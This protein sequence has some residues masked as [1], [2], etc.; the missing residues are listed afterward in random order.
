MPLVRSD[1]DYLRF[2]AEIKRSPH[3]PL[4]VDTETTGLR[5]Y[6]GD[7]I[8]GISI[9]RA[10]RE[11]WYL[12]VNHVD[13]RNFSA[14][15]VLI[16]LNKHPGLLVWH[17]AKFDW[18]MLTKENPRVDLSTHP[19]YDTQVGA[20]YYDEN[21]PTG[22]K[23]NAARLWGEEAKEEQR[24]LK[25]L[26]RGGKTWADLM[27]EEIADY[28]AKDAELTIRLMDSQVGPSGPKP[29]NEI[30]RELRFQGVL[31]RMIARGIRVNPDKIVEQATKARRR[32]IELEGEFEGV[33]LDS[34]PQLRQLVYEDWGVPVKHRTPKGQP[35]TNRQALE[36]LEGHPK[37]RELLEYR[38]LRKAW[39]AYYRPLY[40]TIGDDGRIHPHF[41]STRTV[42]GRL[43]CSDPNLMTI[44]RADTLEGVRDIFLPEDGYE[45]WEY[46]LKSA[47]LFIQASLCKDENLVR[48]LMNGDDL[49]NVTAEMV[50]GPD[51]T[52][53]QRRLAKNL[54]Y[55]FSYG[56]GPRKFAT[57]LVANTPES[58]TEC[59][60]W[61][62]PF[63]LPDRPPRCESCHVCQSAVLLDQYRRAYPRL[64]R[65]MRGLEDAA[66]RDGYLPLHVPGRYR[67]FRSAGRQVP[68][69]TALNAIVQ[70]GVAELVKDVMLGV[71][72]EL[73]ALG[74]RLCLQVHDSLV[75][76]VPPGSGPE[77]GQAIQRV[78]NDVNTFL[79][80]MTWDAQPWS[81]HD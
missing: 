80:P 34:A 59:T 9:A 20:W 71:E 48:A 75:I 47:E 31:Y 64:V 37:V 42:T 25:A 62:W 3:E 6:Q 2:L 23:E 55:G 73:D 33:N 4:A 57:Y 53:L 17:H 38:R 45:L 46:D 70:G 5:P 60:H 10:G 15:D 32:M 51:F 50:F 7:H 22:L 69:Y 14:H 43:S 27:A 24:A 72:P 65:L 41:S 29:D 18:A 63:G 58:V 12:P 26:L 54:N 49:H 68:Y 67:R 74:A 36:E 19:F 56:I 11:G 16:L 79:L 39:S 44:P 13:S 66:K 21:L 40:E 35:S 61:G 76:E 52:G 81:E 30:H 78:T 28:A 77:V 8:T 1:E